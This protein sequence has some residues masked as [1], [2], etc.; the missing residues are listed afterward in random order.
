[1]YKNERGSVG[2]S[3]RVLLSL[4]VGDMKVGQRGLLAWPFVPVQLEHPGLHPW[5]NHRQAAKQAV[6]QE[7]AERVAS[8]WNGAR[9]RSRVEGLREGAPTLSV[10]LG[11]TLARGAPFVV[12]T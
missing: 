4:L 5:L 10:C 9:E 7:T 2:S 1:M 6:C 12:G 8:R 11:S 3:V